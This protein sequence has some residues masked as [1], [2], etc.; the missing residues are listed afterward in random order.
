MYTIKLK[1]PWRIQM[2]PTQSPCSRKQNHEADNGD[3]MWCR[4]CLNKQLRTTSYEA[5]QLEDKQVQRVYSLAAIRPNSSYLVWLVLVMARASSTHM[6]EKH[7]LCIWR[8][9]SKWWLMTFKTGTKNKKFSLG[10]MTE[11]EPANQ[12]R[13]WW[14]HRNENEA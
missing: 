6:E 1:Q 2:W 7:V 4:D 9:N 3:A 13:E 14:C 8:F 12:K 5:V 10:G 11:S